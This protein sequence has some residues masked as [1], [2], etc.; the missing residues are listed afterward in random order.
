MAYLQADMPNEGTKYYMY[1][2]T[3]FVDLE[4]PDYVLEL[5]KPMYGLP[6]AE[7]LW[8][9]AWVKYACNSIGFVQMKSDPCVFKLR[10][11]EE[12]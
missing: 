2:P 7:K 3:G 5:L 8:K 4:H 9:E 12:E 1:Q 10:T 6:I 11:I